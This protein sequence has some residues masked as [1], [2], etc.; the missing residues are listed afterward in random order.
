MKNDNF[1]TMPEWEIP[2]TWEMCGKVK[3]RAYSLERA[4]EITETDDSIKLPKGN[5]VDGSFGLGSEDKEF[6]RFAYN[7][8]QK[9]IY[10]KS[11]KC[12]SCG[13]N[14]ETD[15][16]DTDQYWTNNG[17]RV[18]FHICPQC[19]DSVEEL[20]SDDDYDDEHYTRSSTFGDYSPSCPWNAPG[21]SIKDFI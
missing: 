13:T 6:I 16:C 4:M 21:M 20:I 7:D 8:G 19:G 1:E 10:S 15:E 3:I 12:H 14:V 2:V 9:D 11:M 18:V 17:N 5:Y